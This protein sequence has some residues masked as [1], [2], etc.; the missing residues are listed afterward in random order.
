MKKFTLFFFVISM[1]TC[2]V[3]NAQIDLKINPLGALFSSPDVSAEFN[4]S[5]SIGVEASVGIAFPK[6]TVNGEEF[7]TNGFGLLGAGKYYFGPEDGCDKFFAGLYARYAS[8]TGSSSV[9]DDEVSN[10]RVGAGLLIGYKWVSNKNIIFE[11]DAGFGR[12]FVNDYELSSGDSTDLS[13]IP[14]LNFDGVFR[15]MVGYR[16]GG[17]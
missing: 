1:M 13:D 14:L 4:I 5:E 3:S 10:T 17:N 12:A 2:V 8:T 6:Y 9:S 11:I 7:K 16:L 15:L